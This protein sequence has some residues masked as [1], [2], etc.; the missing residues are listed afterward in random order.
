M[1]TPA[2]IGLGSNL[3]DRQAILDDAV[4]G[5]SQVPGV[6]VRAVSSFHETKPIGGPTGQGP[7]L[8]AAAHLETTLDP[9]Q[10]LAVLQKIENEAGRVRTV[11]WGQRTLDLDLLIFG[12]KFL[13]TKE[14]KLPHPRL[15][16]RRFVLA[17]LAEIA[18]SVVDT[19]TKQTVAELL[20][21]LDRQPRFLAIHGASGRR[22]STVFE[23]LVEELPAFGIAEEDVVGLSTADESDELSVV[24]TLRRK[25]LVLGTSRWALEAL[26]TPWIVTNYFIG[27]DLLR[28]SQASSWKQAPPGELWTKMEAHRAGMAEA[29]KTAKAAMTPT[30][31]LILPSEDPIRRWPGLLRVPQLWPE[32]DKPEAIVAE[33]LATCRGIEA[34]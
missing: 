12:T 20:A 24:E 19:M 8:N 16:F 21:N 4:A 33:V 7:F 28:A 30:F 27:F 11:R 18:P 5:L 31:L 14:L 29:R 3:G 34:I 13:D 10:L 17:P 9:F 32:S 25:A 2:W 1:N 15:A 22:K 26:R 6:V 23:R